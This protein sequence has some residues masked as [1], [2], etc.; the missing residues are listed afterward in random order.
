VIEPP[1]GACDI[2]S[3]TLGPIDLNLLG[4]RVQLFGETPE[5]PITILIYA[6]PG[7]GNL[8]GNLLCAIVGLLDRDAPAAAVANKL[9]QV[10]KI[11]G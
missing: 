9:N 10:L 8:L 6:V 1:E 11:V 3:L 4:L 5:D 7:P 2:L